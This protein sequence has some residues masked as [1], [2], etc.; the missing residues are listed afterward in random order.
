MI[1]KAPIFV[2]L[3]RRR[4]LTMNLNTEILIRTAGGAGK[5]LL[6]TVGKQRN[7]KTGED[8][9]ILGVNLENLRLYLWAALQADATANGETLTQEDIGALLTH[10]DQ[11]VAAL[12]ALM[13]AVNQY[14]GDAPKGEAG[15]P[16]GE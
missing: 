12:A 14:Y 15:A 13:L 9:P 11:V 3:D 4:R 10:R 1:Q 16:A 2:E 7:E 8:E 5:G 6:D